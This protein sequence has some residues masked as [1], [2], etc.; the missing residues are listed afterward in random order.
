MWRT[1]GN[2]DS[3]LGGHKL[4]FA[5]TKTESRGAATPQELDLN[6]WLVLEHL[7]WQHG[8]AGAHHRDG[9]LEGPLWHKPFWSSPLTL[10]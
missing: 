8:T 5:C 1:K 10:P 6:Y 9:A 4:K 7:I 2:R 3:S